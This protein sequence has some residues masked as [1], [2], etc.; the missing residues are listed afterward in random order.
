MLVDLV[1]FYVMLIDCKLYSAVLGVRA[2]IMLWKS[3]NY[4]FYVLGLQVSH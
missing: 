2:I 1:Y 3:G 4:K